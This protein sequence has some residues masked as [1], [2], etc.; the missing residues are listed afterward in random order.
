MGKFLIVH[1]DELSEKWIARL[2]ELGVG[3]LGIHP[4]GGESAHVYIAE[5]L[6]YQKKE[7]VKKIFDDAANEGLNIEYEMH[8][9][10]YLLPRELF[11]EHPEYFRVNAEGKRMQS[12]ECRMLN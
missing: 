2:K 10:S 5:M 1:P 4:V 6:E 7:N 11:S 9:A 3:T 8:V 12:A